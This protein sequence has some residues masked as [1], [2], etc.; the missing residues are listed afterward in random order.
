M[1]DNPFANMVKIG[2]GVLIMCDNLPP[3]S[4]HLQPEDFIMKKTSFSIAALALAACGLIASSAAVASTETFKPALEP[5][6]AAS[7]APSATPAF[8]ITRVQGADKAAFA[9]HTAAAAAA[10]AG[11]A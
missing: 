8:V 9:A 5:A 6:P 7:K 4:I 3:A 1:H 10:Q 2:E 11:R